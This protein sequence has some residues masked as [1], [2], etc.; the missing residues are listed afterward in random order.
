MAIERV[1]D[2]RSV[3][4]QIDAADAEL[5]RQPRVGMK[6]QRLSG[7]EQIDLRRGQTKSI[8]EPRQHIAVRALGA[9]VD[10]PT[11]LSQRE[12]NG[13]RR[14]ELRAK[15][16]ALMVPV[17]EP[18]VEDTP[19]IGIVRSLEGVGNGMAHGTLKPVGPDDHA[20]VQLILAA[21][22]GVQSGAHEFF[23]LFQR[24][25]LDATL[26]GTRQ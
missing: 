24:D 2:M 10:A 15:R 12:G 16:V 23:G 14:R 13:D 25:Q 7:I 5:A 20:R 6:E 1:R 21:A 22:R 18:R 11:F 8:A 3:P 9:E 4:S 19:E 17:H 26:D